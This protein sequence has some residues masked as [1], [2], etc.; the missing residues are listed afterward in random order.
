MSINE[1]FRASSPQPDATSPNG[2]ATSEHQTSAEQLAQLTA[3]IP[4]AS[5]PV[6][7]VDL[8]DVL[9]QTNVVVSHWH[10][11]MYKTDMDLSKFY[12][13]PRFDLPARST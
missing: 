10:N 1:T 13:E 8:D 11:E 7:A 4:P 3:L 2:E 6:I 5:G 9:S 12:C